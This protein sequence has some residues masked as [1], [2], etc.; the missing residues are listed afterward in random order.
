M[1][2]QLMIRIVLLQITFFI[3]IGNSLFAQNKKKA[4]EITSAKTIERLADSLLNKEEYRKALDKYCKANRLFEKNKLWIEIIKSY[5]QTAWCFM[6]LDKIDSAKYFINKSYNL[7]N[8]KIKGTT[9]K[10]K[11]EKSETHYIRARISLHIKQFDSTF[12]Y[13]EKG[14]AIVNEL[15]AEYN[16]YNLLI[17]KYYQTFGTTNSYKGDKD[18]ALKYNLKALDI[19]RKELEK[20]HFDILMSYNNIA[21]T[22]IAKK[23]Y[24]KAK[25]YLWY[26]IKNCSEETRLW[27]ASTYNKLGFV[28]QN[29]QKYNNAIKYYNKELAI[30]V[31]KKGENS[32]EVAKALNNL[33]KVY[34]ALK[35][36]DKALEKISKSVAIRKKLLGNSHP[37]LSKSLLT[38]G[39]YYSLNKE[40]EK[41]IKT[42]LEALEILEKNQSSDIGL[43]Y[44]LYNLT[45][46]VYLHQNNLNKALNY[47]QYAITTIING[48][49]YCKEL[50]NPELF[51]DRTNVINNKYEILSKPA[52][53]YNLICKARTYYQFYKNDNSLTDK[54]QQSLN[55]Y[56]LA[57]QLLDVIRL[58]ISNDDSKYIL[59]DLKKYY[60]NEA[61]NVSFILDSLYPEKQYSENALR[62]IEK[63]KSSILRDN[64]YTANAL[65]KSNLP[66]DLVEKEKDLA[67]KLAFYKT[68]IN[69]N[70]H[71][72]ESN[73]IKDYKNKYNILALEYD[74][75]CN[76][77]KNTYPQ[78]YK[79]THFNEF[80]IDKIKS[81]IKEDEIIVEYFVS[82]SNI[83]IITVNNQDFKIANIPIDNTFKENVI[84]Y[85]RSLRKVEPSN[86]INCNSILYKKLIEPIKD[87]IKT[88][89]NLIIIPDDYLFYIPFET[90]YY[91]KNNAENI[92]FRKLNYLIKDYEI[93]YNFS[94]NIWM[95][96]KALDN[97]EEKYLKDFIGFAPVFEDE[98]NLSINDNDTKTRTIVID[99]KHFSKLIYSE[100]EINE[101][102][103]LFLKRNKKA[104]T[105]FYNDASEDNFKKN[106]SV[107]KY[108]HISTHGFS[109]ESN[110]DLS[111]LAFYNS[112]NTNNPDSTG[113]EDGLLYSSEIRSL[114]L[115]ANLIVLSSCEGGLG[116]LVNEEGLIAISRDFINAGTPN[117]IYSLWNVLDKNTSSLMIDFYKGVLAGKTYSKSLQEVK[118]KM[119]E[120]I[121]TSYPKIWSS[122][123]LM[124]I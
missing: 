95:F 100:K 117:V 88:K 27:E 106:V 60:F 123:I 34:C 121:N 120:D 66:E 59:S 85:Y 10:E 40:H 46:D 4:K 51:I 25:Q 75:V 26:I 80:D 11:L 84:N 98:N 7:F 76:Y 12:Y 83:L 69:I 33:G 3:F 42:Y 50:N 47:F 107:Y 87:R 96:N 97:S 30:Y 17:A 19:R 28:H 78:Y 63:C 45:G 113:I 111:G 90:L 114:D 104:S 68:Q 35:D 6:N 108:I 56:N 102:S 55:T 72:L 16:S 54:I 20:G 112:A 21:L 61:I 43:K 101:I 124:G 93:K 116:K 110:A 9:E 70:N 44:W 32:S 1:I 15:N 38:L 48:F 103:K 94:L 53:Y 58:E 8:H 89:K 36:Y 119:L 118:I 92:D 62:L 13:L 37:I 23:D 74:T 57:F 91:N 86:Y 67:K 31:E 109:N 24:E 49:D 71:Q 81:E 77:L 105:F 64:S 65:K 52:L 115:N 79:L 29:T 82:D 22:Y 73:K 18:N 5:R 99:G 41:A 122:F 39:Q 14:F 2:P